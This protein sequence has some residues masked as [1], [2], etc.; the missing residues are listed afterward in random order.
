[1]TVLLIFSRI[2]LDKLTEDVLMTRPAFGHNYYG[3]LDITR[4]LNI[5]NKATMNFSRY[6]LTS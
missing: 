1:F 4:F 2:T 3:W 5:Y 6:L